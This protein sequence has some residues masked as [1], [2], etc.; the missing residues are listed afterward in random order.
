MHDHRVTSGIEI[1]RGSSEGAADLKE[2]ATA[3]TLPTDMRTGAP[4]PDDAQN[5]RRGTL[6]YPTARETILLVSTVHAY[7]CASADGS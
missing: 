2:D 6:W 4:G 1:N 5:P 7:S 3:G